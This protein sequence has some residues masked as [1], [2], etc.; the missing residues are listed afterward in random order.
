MSMSDHTC[1]RT[2]CFYWARGRCSSLTSMGAEKCGQFRIKSI[3]RQQARPRR[4]D[5]SAIRRNLELAFQQ[6]NANM[7]KGPWA[8]RTNGPAADQDFKKSA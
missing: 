1:N 5:L 7:Q 8:Q 3:A 2:D 4:L 6:E